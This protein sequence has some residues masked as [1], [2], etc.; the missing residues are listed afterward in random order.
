MMAS[1]AYF[2]TTPPK[3]RTCCAISSKYAVRSA[4]SCSG[5]WRTASS[6]EPARSAKS[7]VTSWRSSAGL[8]RLPALDGVDVVLAEADAL[9]A[10]GGVQLEEHR[11]PAAPGRVPLPGAERMGLTLDRVE[12]RGHGEGIRQARLD[13]QEAI[14]HQQYLHVAPAAAQTARATRP[15]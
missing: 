12:A 13:E 4:R 3:A 8:I 1:P 7:T 11:L 15:N 14:V 9:G 6:V 2:S 5:S 10:A